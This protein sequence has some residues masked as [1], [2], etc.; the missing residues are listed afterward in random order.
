M[1]IQPS[2]GADIIMAFDECPCIQRLFM[3]GN[4]WNAALVV[5][6]SIAH[7]DATPAKYGSTSTLS[8]RAGLDVQR[9][10]RGLCGSHSRTRCGGECHWRFE[11]ANH[12]KTLP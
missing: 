4:R 5:D 12:T 2:I 9:P 7:L 8:Y 6:R 11:R 3:P 1:N 10:A